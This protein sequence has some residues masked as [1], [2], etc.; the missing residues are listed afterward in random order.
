MRYW[1]TREGKT[2]QKFATD[3]YAGN[4]PGVIGRMAALLVPLALLAACEN[5]ADTIATETAVAET[6][7]PESLAPESYEQACGQ[8]GLLQVELYGGIRATIDWQDSD[9]SCA[10]MP[11]PD[12]EGARVRM[13]GPVGTEEEIRT[14]AFI[15]GLPELEIGQTG[16]ELATNV[17]L[18]EEG[19]G[20]FFGTRDSGSCWTDVSAHEPIEADDDAGNLYRIKGTLYCVSPLAELNG[21]ASV[22]FTELNF[23]GRLNWGRPK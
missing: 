14:L 18:I 4:G 3:R 7:A 8:D 10:G 2:L 12:G 5:P 9:L 20:R 23:I 19:T 21:N 11:R 16:A 22:T 15:L 1:D 6:L 17:T 13:S